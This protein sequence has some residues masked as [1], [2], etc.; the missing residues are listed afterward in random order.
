RLPPE[1]R[2]TEIQKKETYSNLFFFTYKPLHEMTYEEQLLDP[3]WRYTRDR[4]IERDFG[5]CQRCMSSKNIN[6]HHREYHDGKMAWEYPDRL[7][8]T[9]CT[10]CHREVHNIP[11][12]GYQ[13]EYVMLGKQ[14]A[15][16]K[17]ALKQLL[18]NEDLRNGL[19]VS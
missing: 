10:K 12:D 4:I 6:V 1:V 7:L 2:V 8:I 3:R 13:D 19:P 5:I 18:D 14:L 16:S 9:L 15:H 17:W 11:E